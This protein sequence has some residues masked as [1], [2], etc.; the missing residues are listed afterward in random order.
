MDKK[1][2][3]SQTSHGLDKQKE[4]IVK[5]KNVLLV[6]DVCDIWATWSEILVVMGMDDLQM[7]H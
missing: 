7:S 5:N 1:Y 2:Q 6:C 3:I 4:T